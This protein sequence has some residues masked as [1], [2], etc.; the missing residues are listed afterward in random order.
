M[1]FGPNGSGKSSV[2]D[3]L[4]FLL[5]GEISRLSGEGT[6]D[7][8]QKNHGPHIDEGVARAAVSAKIA[9][10]GLSKPVEIQRTMS[11]PRQLKCPDAAA[12]QLNQL[13]LLAEQRPYVLTRREILRYIAAE[14]GRRAAEVQAVLD[15]SDIENIRKTFVKV[16]NDLSRQLQSANG[17]E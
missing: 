1:I 12:S 5:T 7:I 2:V 6:R 15:L 13:K 10:P 11:N 8:T 14:P 17:Q 16:K 9:L 3:S 4:D